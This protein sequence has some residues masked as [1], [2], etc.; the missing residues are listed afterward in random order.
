MLNI[1]DL[2]VE[3]AGLY[4]C[5][6]RNNERSVDLLTLLIVADVIPR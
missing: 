5:T 1:P 2:G 3:D 6:G 4:V